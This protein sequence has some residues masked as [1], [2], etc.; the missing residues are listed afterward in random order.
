VCHSLSRYASVQL[1]AKLWPLGTSGLPLTLMSYVVLAHLEKTWFV[2]RIGVDR[3]AFRG[4]ERR[5]GQGDTLHVAAREQIV[6]A[7][8]PIP[9]VAKWFEHNRM[10]AGGVSLTMFVGKQVDECRAG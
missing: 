7:A 6:E 9:A 2:R 5:I 4:R 1:H 8:L 10:P 3:I